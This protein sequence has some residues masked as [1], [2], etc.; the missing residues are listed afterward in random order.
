MTIKIIL[1]VFALITIFS[2][3]IA[4]IARKSMID[5][6]N[7]GNFIEEEE[8]NH[9]SR[10]MMAQ[11]GRLDEFVDDLNSQKDGGIVG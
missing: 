11:D 4:Y 3:L 5:G 1:A 8:I 2:L 9:D 7:I 10:K 6:N